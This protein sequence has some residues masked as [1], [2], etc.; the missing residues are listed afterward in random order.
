MTGEKVAREIVIEII[1]DMLG[2]PGVFHDV[3]WVKRIAEAIAAHAAE[4]EEENARLKQPQ[5]CPRH[6]G[7]DCEECDGSG[8]KCIGCLTYTRAADIWQGFL[9]DQKAL[10]GRLEKVVE[11]ARKRLHNHDGVVHWYN[12]SGGTPECALCVALSHLDATR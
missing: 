6:D 12:A 11:A 4:L 10:V 8:F 1:K 5:P 2:E 3:K 9:A 7:P